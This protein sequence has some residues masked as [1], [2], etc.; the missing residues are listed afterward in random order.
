MYSGRSHR[1]HEE[2]VEYGHR[3]VP[4]FQGNTSRLFSPLGNEKELSVYPVCPY[5]DVRFLLDTDVMSGGI[6]LEL[7]LTV[8][9]RGVT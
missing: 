6:R 7:F 4:P 2:G 5:T 8:P 3:R 1:G 9:F